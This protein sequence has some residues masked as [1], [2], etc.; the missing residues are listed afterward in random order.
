VFYPDGERF[1]PPA[2]AQTRMRAAEEQL[3]QVEAEKERLAAKL[4]ELG[5]DPTTL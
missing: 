4:R 3:A 5:I 1:L 2:T